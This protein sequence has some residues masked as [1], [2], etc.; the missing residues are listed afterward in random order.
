MEGALKQ[1]RW[2][3]WIIIFLVAFIATLIFLEL[4]EDVS[5]REDLAR[6]DPVFGAFLVSRT[7]LTGDQVFLAITTLG[8]ALV[9]SGGT[10][11]LS[12]WLIR[13]KKWNMLVFL[14]VVVAG[15]GL[16]NFGLKEIFLRGRPAYLNAFIRDIGYSFPSGHAMISVA[17]YGSLTYILFQ[18]LQSLTRKVGLVILTLI[19]IF[20]IGFSRLYLGVHYLTDVLAGWAIATAWLAACIIST[21][22]ST[23]HHWSP[24]EP[25]LG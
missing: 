7:D 15:C 4:A 14:L 25:N 9:I 22:F 19:V 18:E 20:L 3:R 12:L 17:F 8:N 6:I 1:K 24:K 11:V 23:F 10:V 21:E 2:V 13:R 5:H 16:I